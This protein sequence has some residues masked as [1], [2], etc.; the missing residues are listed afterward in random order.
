MMPST[1][2]LG[3]LGRGRAGMRWRLGSRFR[4]IGFL[5]LLGLVSM[6]GCDR[7]GVSGGCVGLSDALVE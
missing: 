5:W 6:M 2:I 4:M 1:F 7:P 3:G